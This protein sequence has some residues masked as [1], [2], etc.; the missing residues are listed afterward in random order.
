MDLR[1]DEEASAED[2]FVEADVD[3]LLVERE[4]RFAMA[5]MSVQEAT[6]ALGM[7]DHPF[8]VFRNKV[9]ITFLTHYPNS[10]V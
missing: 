1:G 4:K 2:Q 5:P 6:A 10:S 9:M 7:I 3:D 8:Y